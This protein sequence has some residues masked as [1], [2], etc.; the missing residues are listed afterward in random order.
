MKEM[1][2]LSLATIKRMEDMSW[3]TCARIFD[4]LIVVSQRETCCYVWRTERGLVLFDGIWPDQRAYDAIM[5]AIE[6][7]GW[8]NETI[9]AF[10]MTHGHIDHVGCGKWLT[11]AHPVETY[12]S[13]QDDRL[14]L[15][16]PAEE[17]RSERWKTFPISHYIN[18][19]D[20]IR[21]GDERVQVVATPG[22]TAGCMSYLFPVMEGGERHMAGLFGGATAPWG[23]PEGKQLQ[24]RSVER[25]R[26]IA[27]EQHVDV[28]L[29]NH[30]AFD[31]GLERIAYSRE[32][33]QHL[34]NIYILGEDGVQRFC[35]V[36]RRV[37]E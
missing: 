9:V 28:A 22:H 14:R 29:T 37:A 33:M 12:L 5:A 35:S 4:D 20:V 32:R 21:F 25:F 11:E 7:S 18:D 16:T 30:T 24:L 15:A 13:E 23:D 3:F 34:P 19:G 17:G 2:E 26:A 10:F 8:E 27:K 36:F 1:P 6:E 31:N